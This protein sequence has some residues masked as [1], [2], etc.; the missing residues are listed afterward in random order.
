V[1]APQRVTVLTPQGQVV[2]GVTTQ[3]ARPGAR[4]TVV[5]GSGANSRRVTGQVVGGSQAGGR[6]GRSPAVPLAGSVTAT[7]ILPESAEVR[8]LDAGITAGVAAGSVL[9]TASRPTTGSQLGW[10]AF[11][12][13]LGG[14]MAVEGRG[15]L[16]DAGFGVLSSNA[17]YLALRLLHP[18]LGT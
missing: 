4:V 10:A 16:Q 13:L 6:S 5:V 18:N 11:W 8:F 15:E 7:S 2:T 3:R 12:V 14:L 17:S 9:W 1:A